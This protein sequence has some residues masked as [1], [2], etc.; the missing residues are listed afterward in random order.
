ME[1]DGFI[2][3]KVLYGFIPSI[4][5]GFHNPV[6]NGIGGCCCCCCVA[7]VMVGLEGLLLGA[8]SD[9]TTAGFCCNGSSWFIIS[10]FPVNMTPLDR[11]H[12]SSSSIYSGEGDDATTPSRCSVACCCC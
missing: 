5:F 2:G 1:V 3:L 4:L 11:F 6:S 12:L 7:V 10:S 8:A 9:A